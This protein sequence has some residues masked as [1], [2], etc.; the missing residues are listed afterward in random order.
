MSYSGNDGP[1]GW[2]K[3]I[4]ASQSNIVLGGNGNRGDY[5]ETIIVI[6]TTLV[7][8]SVSIQDGSN[9]AITI[10]NTGTLVDLKPFH[11][12]VKAFSTNGPWKVTTGANVA[13]IAT[14]RF[15]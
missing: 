11:V 1:A 3:S 6:P 2:Y 12:Y 5:L 10:Y 8:G 4:L 13:V 9:T 14:G 15:T 7:A